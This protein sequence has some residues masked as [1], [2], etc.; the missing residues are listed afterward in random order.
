M[1]LSLVKL[2][3]L[4]ALQPNPG[5]NGEEYGMLGTPVSAMLN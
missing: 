4:T 2:W 1:G 3:N 5:M